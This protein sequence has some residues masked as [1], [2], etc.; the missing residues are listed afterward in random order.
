M[1]VAPSVEARAKVSMVVAR[2]YMLQK[3]EQIS[4]GG[5]L[6]LQNR[7]DLNGSGGF[8]SHVFPPLRPS[9]DRGPEW[10]NMVSRSIVLLLAYCNR[11]L[12]G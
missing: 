1:E 10:V 5:L 3:R 11:D 7:R 9:G 2:F 12:S 8:D 4:S 6:G